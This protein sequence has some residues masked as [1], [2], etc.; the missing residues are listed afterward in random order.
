VAGY[1]TNVGAKR[2]REYRRE[3]GLA[4]DEP[5]DCLVKVVEERVGIPVAVVDIAPGFA[6]AYL[7]RGGRASIF[8]HAPDWPTRK[9]F[10]LAHELGHHRLG[11]KPVIDTWQAM[12]AS[13]RPPEETQANAFAAE[14]VA[15]KAGI[16][17]WLSEHDHPPIDLELV[18]RLSATFGL[19]AEATRYLLTTIGVLQNAKVAA[20]LDAEIQARE[21]EGLVEHLGLEY[22]DDEL[23]RGH[24]KGPRLPAGDDAGLLGAM[25]RGTVDAETA[26][27]LTGRDPKR[28]EREVEDAGI[29]S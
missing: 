18:C 9:R 29:P 25:L 27:A 28:L 13:D 21:H 17:R 7:R 2:A 1:D 8:V 24:D 11:H 6:G 23:A 15:P 14:F 20:R 4:P 3:L 16:M 12:Y 19:S 5:L 22:P 26:A 10:S